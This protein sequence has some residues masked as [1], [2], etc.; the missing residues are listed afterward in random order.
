MN[1]FEALKEFH[2][3]FHLSNEHK[4]RMDDIQEEPIGFLQSINTAVGLLKFISDD[5]T[6]TERGLRIKLLCEEMAEYLEAEIEDNPVEIAD[7]LTD[8][9]Y[10]AAGTCCSYGIDGEACF[11]HVH[12]NNMSKLG[13]DGLP[14]RREDGKILKPDDYTP[15]NLAPIV[16]RDS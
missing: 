9:I 14:I 2:I 4:L 12:N 1:I 13:P 10:I 3:A 15:P 7:A 16:Y 5:R 8:V 11:T 6:N